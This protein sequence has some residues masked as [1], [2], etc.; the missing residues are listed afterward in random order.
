MIPSNPSSCAC[1]TIG[2]AP[3]I[4]RMEPSNASS[5]IRTYFFSKCVWL[6][7]P[8]AAKIPIAIGRSNAVPLFR[9]SAGARLIT[10][11]VLG[12]R[13]PFVLNV[14]SILSRLS[15]TALSGS[16]TI[17][18]DLPVSSQFTSICMQCASMPTNALPKTVTNMLQSNRLTF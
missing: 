1:N 17:V 7:C 16:P 3:F 5:P 15:R 11:L 9:I 18:E 4:E 13:K 6:S 2:S 12:N 14:L 8:E 10:N